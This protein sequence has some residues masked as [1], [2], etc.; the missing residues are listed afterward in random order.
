MTPSRGTLSWLTMEMGWSSESESEVVG[1]DLLVM[2]ALT[3]IVL[4]LENDVEV[5]VDKNL[6]RRLEKSG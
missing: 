1:F 2:S 6:G 4:W 3:I 5:V